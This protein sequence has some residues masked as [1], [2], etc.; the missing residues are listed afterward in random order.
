MY[1]FGCCTRV[2]EL[3]FSC[4]DWGCK[5]CRVTSWKGINHLLRI[6]C[7]L[8]ELLCVLFDSLVNIGIKYV[9]KMISSKRSG[10]LIG[11]TRVQQNRWWERFRS[12]LWVH[13]VS[14]F[15]GAFFAFATRLSHEYGTRWTGMFSYTSDIWACY[16]MFS[17]GAF[18]STWIAGTAMFQHVMD[19]DLG[20]AWRCSELILGGN[21]FR[22]GKEMKE[23]LIQGEFIGIVLNV[24]F[25]FFCFCLLNFWLLFFS[26]YE[27]L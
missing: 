25:F 6:S 5:S 11:V 19:H 21:M 17:L 2:G 7:V 13:D 26:A 14:S 9:A 8:G 3:R 24:T 12:P 16:Y 10:S 22:S 1:V 4:L 18:I 20:D 27:T 15:L 23:L